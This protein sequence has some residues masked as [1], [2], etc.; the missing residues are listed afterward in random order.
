MVTGDVPDC[1]LFSTCVFLFTMI[2]Y[3]DVESDVLD[4]FSSPNALRNRSQIARGPYGSYRSGELALNLLYA[5][6]GITTHRNSTRACGLYTQ[7]LHIWSLVMSRNVAYF[8]VRVFPSCS[9]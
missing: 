5:A 4:R 8:L 3:S 1:R 7:Q 6:G 9:L 2:P